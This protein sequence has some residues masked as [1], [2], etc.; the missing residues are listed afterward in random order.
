MSH[1]V[2]ITANLVDLLN[3]VHVLSLVDVE[4]EEDAAVIEVS[5]R[6]IQDPGHQWIHQS[7]ALVPDIGPG[8]IPK[9]RFKRREK[10]QD[11]EIAQVIQAEIRIGHDIISPDALL[12]LILPQLT[13]PWQT[14]SV[15]LADPAE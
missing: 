7:V 8:A 6:F 3:E 15:L 4:D 9:D 10:D 5:G 1:P 12:L 13:F 14:F 11:G 2:S